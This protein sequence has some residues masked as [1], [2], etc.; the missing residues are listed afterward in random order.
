VFYCFCP[1]IDVLFLSIKISQD[2]YID[3]T[4]DPVVIENLPDG[5]YQFKVAT[6]AGC[7][8]TPPFGVIIITY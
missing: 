8:Q 6:P 4:G 2:G 7:F 1:G 5:V 3:G